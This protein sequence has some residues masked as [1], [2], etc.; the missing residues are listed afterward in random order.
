V[1]QTADGMTFTLQNDPNGPNAIGAGNSFFGYG[2]SAGQ[3]GIQNSAAVVTNIYG[4]T[5]PGT[6]FGTNGVAPTTFSAFDTDLNSLETTAASAPVTFNVT[7][8]YNPSLQTLT[9][10][11]NSAAGA[12]THIFTGVNYP[13]ILGSSSAYAGF[14]GSSGFDYA[15]QSISNFTF[16]NYVISGVSGPA[17]IANNVTATPSTSSVISLGVSTGSVAGAIGTLSI[18]SG[19]IVKIV[20]DSADGIATRGVLTTTGLSISGSTDGWTGKLDL[21]NNA[22]DVQN[23]DIV[24][25]TNQ[26]RQGYSNGTWQGSGGIT[27][28]SAA[29]DPAHLT[30]LGV[31]LNNTNGSTPLYGSSGAL[32]L[33][34]GISPAATDVLVRLT[35]YG[36][37]DLNG[38]VDG[39]DYSRIDNGYLNGLTGWYNGDF[40]YDGIINGSDYTLIDNA[41]NTQGAS[42]AASIAVV[43]TAQVS[44]AVPE[45]TVA[46]LLGVAALGFVGRR[47]RRYQS[48]PASRRPILTGGSPNV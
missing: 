2:A 9:E 32:G 6:A 28:V 8:S 44:S 7:L 3:P 34:D 5:Q 10:T 27:S 35:Y 39:S 46:G 24:A 19:A 26:V 14:T 47:R 45:P 41:F 15:G 21:T 17:S 36:D 40:N 29:S 38:V 43:P 13:S 25:I 30:A 37:T 31:L 18:G 33:F 48:L 12:F 4:I 11:M 42:L 20:A 23:G 16:G 1:N 22:L